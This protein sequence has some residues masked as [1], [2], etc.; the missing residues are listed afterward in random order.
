MDFETL[1]VV[2][3]ET[4]RSLFPSPLLST[5]LAARAIEIAGSEAQRGRWLPGLADGTTI[6][7]LALLEESDRYDAQGV[8][9]RAVHDGGSSSLSGRKCFVPDAGCA[10]LFVV[11]Y[12][13]SA[14][15][16]AISL[17]VIEK[18]DA[19]VE[20]GDYESMDLTKRLGELRLDGARV[21]DTN[22]LG[23]TGAAWPVIEKLIDIGAVLVTAEAVGA[24]EAALAITTEFAKQRVQFGQPIGRFQSVKHP[25][26]DMHVDIESF[27]SLVYYA[28]WCIDEDSEDLPVAVSRA[29]AYA[30][31]SFPKLGIDGVQLHGGVGY[32]WEYDI[33]LYLKRSKWARP[34]YGDVDFHY[35]RIANLGGL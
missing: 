29:K 8:E 26:A 17:A 9:L 10:D 33:Q 35:D 25:L 4:G 14:D 30:S 24:A 16:E 18:T 1:V 20:A 13:E 15:P 21:D 34:I 6:G 19:G 12:R 7:T 27:K 28:A 2:L 3:E 22:R 11:A 23:A 5:V 32:T 31:E